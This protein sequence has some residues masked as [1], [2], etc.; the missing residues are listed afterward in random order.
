MVRVIVKGLGRD[1]T[2]QT[3]AVFAYM[4]QGPLASPGAAG[5]HWSID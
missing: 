1:W 3:V 2:F 5:A 4:G